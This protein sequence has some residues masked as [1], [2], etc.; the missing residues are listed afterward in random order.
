MPVRMVSGKDGDWVARL[1]AAVRNGARGVLLA[2]PGPADPDEVRDAARRAT[3]AGTIVAV[4]AGYTADRTWR[5]ALPAWQEHAPGAQLLDSVVTIDERSS[6]LFTAL[7][8]QLTVVRPIVGALEGLHLLHRSDD[9]YIASARADQLAITL[10]GVVSGLET[11]TLRVDLVG[12]DRRWSARFD[13]DALARP[14]LVTRFDADGSTAPP[15]RY[16][17]PHRAAWLDLHAAITDGTPPP[18]TLEALATDLT[19]ANQVLETRT[20]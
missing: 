10:T 11:S 13:G 9:Q 8:D 16:E 6:T 5:H 14:A 2:A 12:V 19:I 3:A 20:A 1:L 18:Y 15:L 4:D 17:S 7:I